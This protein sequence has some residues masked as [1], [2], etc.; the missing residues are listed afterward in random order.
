[1][2][3]GCHHFG[4]IENKGPNNVKRL[5]EFNNIES[6]RHWS[7]NITCHLCGY[8]MLC[9]AMQGQKMI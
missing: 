8:D 4:L 7:I 9:C 2:V 3:Y 6:V 1:M 5:S